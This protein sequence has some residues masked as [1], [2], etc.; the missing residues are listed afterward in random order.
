MAKDFA[1]LFNIDK[2]LKA[3][4]GMDADARGWYVNLL[5]HQYDKNG[6]PNNVEDLALLAGVR[7]SE[8]Q[9]FEQVFEQVLKQ[10]FVVDDDGKL[11]NPYMTDVLSER[12]NFQKKR[13]LA[14]KVSA[15]L[16]KIR[17]FEGYDKGMDAIFTSLVT[18]ETDTKSEQVLQQMFEICS[19]RLRSR[20]IDINYSIN[21]GGV[22]ETEQ[23]IQPPRYIGQI[24]AVPKHKNEAIKTFDR[25]TLWFESLKMCCKPITLDE[26]QIVNLM[27]EF[28]TFCNATG[29]NEQRPEQ[30][31]KKHFT[32]WLKKKHQNGELK[33]K[34]KQQYK[35][36]N[37]DK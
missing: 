10:K 16:R 9:R 22:G 12:V 3:T 5:L 19:E 1:V 34:P 25:N 4:A 37:F 33:P 36:F 15:G 20:S 30:E 31:I 32:N 21:E 23:P 11:R 28:I 29:K 26:N 13:S 18:E 6:L 7:F 24:S 2:W 17:T 27:D 14:G 8:Y 35:K